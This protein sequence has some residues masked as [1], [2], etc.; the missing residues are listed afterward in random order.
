MTSIVEHINKFKIAYGVGVGVVLLAS[1]VWWTG[2]RKDTYSVRINGVVVGEI[3]TKEEA[4]QALEA[5]VKQLENKLEKDIVIT[6]Q[7]TLEHVNGSKDLKLL[8]EELTQVFENELGYGI[9]GIAIV[10]D[11]ITQAVV[12]DEATAYAA[13]KTIANSQLKEYEAVEFLS[14]ELIQEAE[15]PAGAELVGEAQE[16]GEVTPV[17]EAK[18]EAVGQPQAIPKEADMP[19]VEVEQGVEE[20]VVPSA[21][22]TNIK[23]IAIDVE[24]IEHG[25]PAAAKAVPTNV[26]KTCTAFDFNKEVVLEKTYVEEGTLL[27]QQEVEDILLS[28]TDEVVTYEM[29]PGDNVWDIAVS[30]DTTMDRILELNPQIQDVTRMQIGEVIKVEAPDPVLAIA[31]TEEAIFKEIIVAD[32]EYVES[33]S[34]F[35]GE[36]KV[37]QAGNDGM[38]EISVLVHRVNGKEVNREHLSEKILQEPNKK[39]IAYGTKEK[40]KGSAGPSVST[41]NAG[42]FM[43][44]L[45]WAGRISSPYGSRWGTFHRGIDLAASKGTPIY[46]AASGTVIYSGY[47]NGGFGN[48]VMIDHGNGYQTYYA[49]NSKNHVQVGQRVVKGQN[50]ASV[51][52]TGNSTGNHVHFEIR[53]NGTPINPNSY[54]Y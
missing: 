21:L 47:N 14:Q 28:N 6:D 53:K 24:R 33:D 17:D 19:V 12:E 30:N 54:I 23:K 15:V 2:I 29:Q 32:I 1:V 51:G 36:E 16:T 49:H 25:Q 48:L 52:S 3:K 8:P 11:G 38:K 22:P 7:I 18:L 44:P 34:L 39:V 43:H 5:A 46:A 50:I 41:S 10:V 40:P 35:K 27:T 45:N 20:L 13:L 4:T 26:K 42:K 31:T 9:E 37:K